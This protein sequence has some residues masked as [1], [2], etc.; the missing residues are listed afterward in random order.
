MCENWNNWRNLWVNSDNDELRNFIRRND[1]ELD[2]KSL[3]NRSEI[4]IFVNFFELV[5]IL[6]IFEWSKS[7]IWIWRR[8]KISEVQK[9]MIG[10]KHTCKYFKIWWDNGGKVKISWNNST[11]LC[12]Q[13]SKIGNWVAKTLIEK[14]R[15]FRGKTT[16][17]FINNISTYI[18][19]IEL[20][21]KIEI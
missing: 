7:D 11:E 12:S 8:W 5:F 20:W 2:W 17:I 4:L 3:G 13:S 18:S 19:I 6:T 15:R 1:N 16:R 9:L 14:M 21:K 10:W